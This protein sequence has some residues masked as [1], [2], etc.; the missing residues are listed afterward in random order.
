MALLKGIEQMHISE[1]KARKEWGWKIAYNLDE[2]V[3]D[4]IQEFHRHSSGGN[5]RLT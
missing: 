5:Q 4:F 2:M 1:E 3:D